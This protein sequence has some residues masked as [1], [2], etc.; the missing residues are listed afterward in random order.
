M[1]GL[2]CFLF[3]SFPAALT[4]L[5][6]TPLRA[7]AWERK[8][9]E[10]RVQAGWPAECRGRKSKRKKGGFSKINFLSDSGRSAGPFIK[11]WKT[12]GI[13][14]IHVFSPRKDFRIS[15]SHS[16][17]YCHCTALS[18]TPPRLDRSPWPAFSQATREI[19]SLVEIDVSIDVWCPG[20]SKSGFILKVRTRKIHPLGKQKPQGPRHPRP[21][22]AQS[23]CFPRLGLPRRSAH[24]IYCAK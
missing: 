18:P 1:A 19:T 17:I 13:K 16:K 2:V 4:L 14:G 22:P 7:C 3:L 20:A 5:Q 10:H 23:C 6:K 21:A 9:F 12:E 11:P 8:V 15:M 24:L